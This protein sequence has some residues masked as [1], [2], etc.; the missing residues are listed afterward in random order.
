MIDLVYVGRGDRTFGPFSSAQLRGL[1]EAGRLRAT[2]VLWRE[3]TEKRVLASRV[4]NLFPVP[5]ARAPLP[6]ADAPAVESDW[7]LPDPPDG[8]VPLEPIPPL[9]AAPKKKPPVPQPEKPRKRRAVGVKGAI[10]LGQD[11]VSVHYRKKC[12]QCG[13]EDGC[14][15]SMRIGQGVVRAHFY[16]PKCRKNRDVQIQGM[17]Q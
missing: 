9:Q 2:D 16:C 3:G 1:A 17:M 4:Q 13:F 6:D 10:L 15:S 5:Q 12:W 11:G 7:S 14:R 8:L